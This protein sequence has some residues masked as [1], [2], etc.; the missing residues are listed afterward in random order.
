MSSDQATNASPTLRIWLI[1]ARPRTLALAIASVGMGG[2]LAAA[3]NQFD[4]AIAAL[5]LLTA[6]LLQTLSN[7]A[8]DYGD[9]IHGADRV[10]RA[11]PQRAVQSGQISAMAMRRLTS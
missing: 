7:L 6:T 11:G 1:A 3:A 9:S 4:W 2:F 5:S 8:N 10:K